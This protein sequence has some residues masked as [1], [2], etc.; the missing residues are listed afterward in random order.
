MKKKG[1]SLS[2]NFTLALLI[3]VILLVF[4]L[5]AGNFLGSS[6]SLEREYISKDLALLLDTVYASPSDLEYRYVLP[7][8]IKITAKDNI[9][10]AIDIETGQSTGYPFASNKKFIPINFESKT[11]IREIIIKKKSGTI[12]LT[13]ISDEPESGA[14]E[15]FNG[16]VS[17]AKEKIGKNYNFR[18]KE[19][20]ELQLRPK[21]YITVSKKGD[22]LLFHER[23]GIPLQLLKET[24]PLFKQL[25]SKTNEDFFLSNGEFKP[26]TAI[27]RRYEKAIIV[28]DEKS[29]TWLWAYPTIEVNELPECKSEE[30]AR[31]G[32][33]NT[34]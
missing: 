24:I 9:I 5:L 12:T 7:K 13:G 8:E 15:A 6:T 21:Y 28:N 27:I 10:K 26:D 3:L 23:E 1:E 19:E 17:F 16:F 11:P 22:A 29:R 31:K 2:L 34:R 25:N 33:Q 14:I 18:C 20:L 30:S 4:L 32:L